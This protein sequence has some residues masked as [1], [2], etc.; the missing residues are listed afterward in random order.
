MPL[1][2]FTQKL[3]EALVSVQGEQRKIEI[4]VWGYNEVWRVG[5]RGSLKFKGYNT[6]I[7]MSRGQTPI[8]CHPQ[9]MYAY[10]LE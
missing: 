9:G 5:N 3:N 1:G 8:S 6:E 10:F 4:S 7:I 2:C